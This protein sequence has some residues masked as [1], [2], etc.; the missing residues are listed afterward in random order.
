[1]IGY[2]DDNSI[3]FDDFEIFIKKTISFEF[4]FFYYILL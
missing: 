3:K 2:I 1:M 4:T